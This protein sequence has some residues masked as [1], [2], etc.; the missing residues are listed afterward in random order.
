MVNQILRFYFYNTIC[1]RL[2]PPPHI[3][4]WTPAVN[5]RI[6]CPSLAYNF[7]CQLLLIYTGV[8]LPPGAYFKL[9][10]SYPLCTWIEWITDDDS[11]LLF[12]SPPLLYRVSILSLPHS[13]SQLNKTTELFLYAPQPWIAPP[14]TLRDLRSQCAWCALLPCPSSPIL[15]PFAGPSPPPPPPPS[16]LCCCC[17]CVSSR[18][19]VGCLV[20]IIIILNISYLPY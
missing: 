8:H 13:I 15:C 1:L 4:F 7:I 18:R 3:Y 2:T 10:D 5:L 19:S 9:L 14:L 17:L 16:L 6:S 20:Y 12:L 11:L